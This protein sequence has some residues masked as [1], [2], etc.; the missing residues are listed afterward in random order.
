M[1]RYF[2]RF[3]RERSYLRGRDHPH[4][5]PP[6]GAKDGEWHTYG[7]DLGHTRYAPLDQINSSNFKSCKWRGASRQ[8]RSVRGRNI[9]MRAPR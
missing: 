1:P 4:C 5:L 3:D 9:N 6:V 2:H 7:G 8:T